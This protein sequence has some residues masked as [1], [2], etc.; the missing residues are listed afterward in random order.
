M[1]DLNTNNLTD[2]S[3]KNVEKKTSWKE[4]LYPLK[5][6]PKNLWKF[7]K[8]DQNVFIIL[9]SIE[10]ICWFLGISN[11]SIYSALLVYDGPFYTYAAKTMYHIPEN[12]LFK[13]TN[14][15]NPEYMAC[16]FP[17]YPI[18]IRI[19]AF[20]CFNNYVLGSLLS[21]IVTSYFSIYI[22]RRFL[23]V[24]DL[25]NDPDLTAYL[26]ICIPLRL[27][28]YKVVGASEP[29]Y[30]ICIFAS[31]IFFKTNQFLFL[32][33][34][35]LGATLTRIEGLSIVGTIGLCYLIKFDI[36]RA[37][38]CS[39]GALGTAAVF[40]M[41]YVC[42][43]NVHAYFDHNQGKKR[44]L[45]IPFIDY[46]YYSTDYTLYP[47]VYQKFL[48]H[49]I[50]LIPLCTLWHKSI[51]LCIFILTYLIYTAAIQHPD[52][53]R[54]ASPAYLPALL[55]GFDFIISLPIVKNKIKQIMLT[56]VVLSILYIFGQINTNIM[57]KEVYA[58]VVNNSRPY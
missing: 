50:L 57:E 39:I 22:F 5:K 26:S 7:D 49:S 25:V 44:L 48:M 43:H 12:W 41:H 29:L 20:V 3:D 18:V 40:Y 35:L 55:I 19:C 4:S 37:A 47:M 46:L 56:Y 2:Q 24:Y 16:H 54:Y 9:I 36:I 33:L 34:S 10:A 42:F 14:N 53:F 58:Q 23:I 51:P 30:I 45:D 38:L 1:I 31:M 27:L 8:V 11:G 21:I 52:I 28:N 15:M 17:G 32:L 6:I 13:E